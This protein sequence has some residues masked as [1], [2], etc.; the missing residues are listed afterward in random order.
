MI[1]TGSKVLVALFKISKTSPFALGFFITSIVSMLVEASGLT[2]LGA[3]ELVT[4]FFAAGW[5]PGLAG[6][7]GDLGVAGRGLLWGVVGFLLA[8]LGL[9]M[10]PSESALGTG[11][12]GGCGCGSWGRLAALSRVW[13][14]VCCLAGCWLAAES[15]LSV[16][17]SL[18]DSSES[19]VFGPL[20]VLRTSPLFRSLTHSSV[21]LCS[22]LRSCL[23]WFEESL[24]LSDSWSESEGELSW[25]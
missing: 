23:A 5:L 7:L 8:L 19:D 21:T 1:L 13:D 9:V 17:S 2:Y 14:S 10:F 20:S 12:P 22:K 16:M 18:L 6:D 4:D 3:V 25:L 15:C 11:L 24:L